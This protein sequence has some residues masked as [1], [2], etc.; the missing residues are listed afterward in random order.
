MKPMSRRWFLASLPAVAC[1][2][3]EV[4]GKGR[5]LPS[6]VSRYA[7]GTTEFTIQR[8][9]SPSHTSLLPP[10]YARAVS[11]RSNFLLYASDATG[12][13]EAYRLDLKSGQSKQLT[14]AADLDP[15]SLTLLADDRG[16]CCVDGNK[17][18]QI[19]L[20][21]LKPREVYAIPEGFTRGRGLSVAED[22]MYAAVIER[23]DSR[24][25]LQL[26]QMTSGAATKLA[27]TDDE[28][29]DPIPRPKR[30]SILYRR[31]GALWLV[32]YDGQQNYRLRLAEGET[33]P[34][35]WS[36]DGRAVL[37]LNYPADKHKLNNIREFITDTNEDKF[38]SDTSQ[39]IEFG[40]NGDA[41]V[42]VGASGS[43]ASP[44]VLLLVRSVRRE[45]TLAEH[46]AKDP[47]IV[48]PVFAPNSQRI[49]FGSDLHGKPA[50]YT[51]AVEKFVEETD[52]AG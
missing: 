39:Y 44:H 34:G 10:S 19:G 11:R 9:T 47:R 29:R 27:E 33:G 36:P 15:A 45:M 13:F 18:L 49:F 1:L 22:G 23:K 16:F 24:H 2:G 26:V 48:A 30:A 50:I 12:R 42:F 7:D 35:R 3:S 20:S 17:L 14:E 40:V 41:S 4:T 46:R 5:T 8:L 21:S 31:S 51:M 28:L 38:V 37:Y 6:E 43:K 25:R 52:S 32:N